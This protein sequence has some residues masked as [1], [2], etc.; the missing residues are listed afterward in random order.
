VA[1]AVADPLPAGYTPVAMVTVQDLSKRF[2]LHPKSVRE[3]LAALGPLVSP[4]MT[5]GRNNAILL[6]DA[7][8][9]LFDRLIQLEREGYPTAT[10]VQLM[11]DE[12]PEAG[13][14][15]GQPEDNGAS[16][17]PPSPSCEH[18]ELIRELRAR[19]ESLEQDKAY[20]KAKLDELLTRIPELPPGPPPAGQI[21]NVSRWQALK[22]A[23]LGR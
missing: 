23:L 18:D 21:R 20:L 5:R 12:L 17:R 13:Q 22:Y 9:A 1:K 10:A 2:G 8:L 6:T 15:G 3:R 11:R 7:G 16:H 4:H 14:T 19:I